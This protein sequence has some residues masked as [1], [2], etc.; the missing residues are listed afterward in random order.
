VHHAGADS[1][2]RAVKKS[3]GELASGARGKFSHS[4]AGLLFAS[5]VEVAALPDRSVS[6][7]LQLFMDKVLPRDSWFSCSA[8]A[9]GTIRWF[10]HWVGGYRSLFKLKPQSSS[11]F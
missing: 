1:G 2:E 7:Q 8:V 4:L 11:D 9:T 3:P 10:G 6:I 5:E